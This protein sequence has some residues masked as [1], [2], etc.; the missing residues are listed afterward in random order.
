MQ[1]EG[2]YVGAQFED[3]QQH[4]MKTMEAETQRQLLTLQ[5]QSGS[6]EQ[7]VLML[8]LLSSFYSVQELSPWNGVLQV[9]GCYSYLS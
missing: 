3:T 7:W 9:Q 6:K 4:D 5:P 1:A 8:S 2:V